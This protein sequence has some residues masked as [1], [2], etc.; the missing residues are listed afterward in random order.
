MSDQI[1]IKLGAIARDEAAYLP[2]WIFHHLHFGVDEIEIY[3]NNTV[4]NSFK[5][6]THIAKNHPVKITQAD[7]LFKSPRGDFQARAY[8]EMTEKAQQD[9]FTH[10]IFLDIDEFW[11]PADFSTSIKEALSQF[12]FPDVLNFNWFIHCDESE[13]SVCY[14]KQL[15]IQ[16]NPHVK[17]LFRLDSPWKKVSIHNV[18]GKELCYTRGDGS[19]YDFGDSKHCGISD[20][21]CLHHKFY[22]IHRMYRSQKE[23]ISLLGR[24]RANKVKL[25]DNRYGYYSSNGKYN[26]IAFEPSLLDD[27]YRRYDTFIQ[28]C[29]LQSLVD[30]SHTFV[31]KRYQKV[32]N[33]A[34]KASNKEAPI[35]LK[36]FNQIDLA[37]VGVVRQSL[38]NKIELLPIEVG[39]LSIP[40]FRYLLLLLLAKVLKKIGFNQLALKSLFHAILIGGEVNEVKMVANIENALLITGFPNN[41]HADIYREIAIRFHRNNEL[42]L[43]CAFIA[44]AKDTRPSGSLIIK[45]YNKYKKERGASNKSVYKLAKNITNKLRK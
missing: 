17:S 3:V 5:V 22:V 14:K 34:R 12:N 20:A 9:D 8:K 1:K 24:G 37:D 25:K 45:L 32:I 28:Q 11:T 35:F 10:M 13:F 42:T 21:N 29:Q 15:K 7:K 4:D 18:L 31:M 27:Y 40:K 6:L 43:A 38:L 41:K 30:N 44:K 39:L 16:P 36:L 2:E 19:I 23:Y 26:S 33:W